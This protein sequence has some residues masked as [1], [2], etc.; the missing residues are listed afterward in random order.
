MFG[1]IFLYDM[2]LDTVLY[3]IYFKILRFDFFRKIKIG[4]KLKRPR[5]RI[6]ITAEINIKC[7]G[8]L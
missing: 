5:N 4:A 6:V 3:L 7:G 2:P 1:P 8:M